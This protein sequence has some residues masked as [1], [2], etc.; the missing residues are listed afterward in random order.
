MNKI[1]NSENPALAHGHA[2]PGLADL[3]ALVLWTGCAG[4]TLATG[5][6]LTFPEQKSARVPTETTLIKV[7]LVDGDVPVERNPTTASRTSEKSKAA[8]AL[9][10]PPAAAPVLEP[11]ATPQVVAL[12]IPAQI[13]ISTP[14]AEITAPA[15]TATPPMAVASGSDGQD[16]AAER[17]VYGVGEG[18][19]PAPVYP[20]HAIRQNQTGLVRVRFTVGEDGGVIDA[21]ASKPCQWTLLNEAAVSTVRHRWRFAAGKV[22]VYEVEISF[23]LRE[24]AY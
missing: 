15:L 2:P 4:I 17:I 21:V 1:E 24:K 8:V 16:A 22:R 10:I 19:Q 12:N 9:G 18:V 11:E 20:Y 13:A 6:G 7:A 14:V 5:T 3:C 23:E